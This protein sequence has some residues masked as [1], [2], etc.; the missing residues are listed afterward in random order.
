MNSNKASHIAFI[1]P[2]YTYN[3][4]TFSYFPFP[5]FHIQVGENTFLRFSSDLIK[6]LI[7]TDKNETLFIID[8]Y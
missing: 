8:S 1:A 4:T 6:N 2:Y 3:F 7:H 5:Y